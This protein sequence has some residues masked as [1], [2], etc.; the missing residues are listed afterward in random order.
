MA[1]IYRAA[2][3]GDLGEVQRLVEG[4]P[5]LLQAVDEYGETALSYAA[6]FGHLAVVAYLLNQGA[7]INQCNSAA[8]C[9]ACH[10]GHLA[11]ARLLLQR[12]ADPALRAPN[13]S[14]PMMEAS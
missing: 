6:A 14:T 12:G 1:R 3:I 7:P 11:V 8:L 4:D 10:G 13:G 9:L 2:E 5:G